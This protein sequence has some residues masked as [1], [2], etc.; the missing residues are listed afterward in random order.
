MR[1]GWQDYFM[2]LVA[3][4]SSRSQCHSR[5]VGAL[6]VKDKSIISTGYNGVPSGVS[7][8]LKCLRK[9]L[10]SGEGYAVCPAVHAEANAIA[11]AAKLG[12]STYGA[13]IYIN[14]HPC[15]S[16]VGLIINAGIVELVVRNTDLKDLL[17]MRIIK[18]SSLEVTI[19]NGICR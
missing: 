9:G 1:P 18:E 6:I 12:I 11:Q 7:P 4:A 15:K 16:C 19:I 10:P 2:R 17:A 3:A 5:H 14:C 8:C 13:A